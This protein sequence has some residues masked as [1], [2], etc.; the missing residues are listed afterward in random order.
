MFCPAME[1]TGS[2][3]AQVRAAGVVEVWSTEAGK[4]VGS[5]ELPTSSDP[6]YT[7]RDCVA[8][9][10]VVLA[11]QGYW[12]WDFE[13]DKAQEIVLPE[14]RPNASPCLA[15]GADGGTIVVAH[16]H[17]TSN[18]PDECCV[19]EVCIYRLD[20]GELL[21]N[22]VFHKDYL[23]SQIGAIALSHDGRELAL[24]WDFGPENPTRRLVHMHA[25]NGKVLKII[26][27]LPPADQGYVPAPAG[28]PRS[29]LAAR[30][31]R[32]GRQSPERC[33]CGDRRGT[34]AGIARQGRHGGRGGDGRGGRSGARRRWS[35]PG[36]HCRSSRQ[37]GP[38]G[39]PARE[40]H[41]LAE[42]RAVPVTSQASGRF[43]CP[44]G[45]CCQRRQDRAE[46]IH[47]GVRGWAKWW[48]GRADV[49]PHQ[50]AGRF[51]VLGV[52]AAAFHKFQQRE[53]LVEAIAGCRLVAPFH[54][55]VELH[56]RAGSTLTTPPTQPMAPTTRLGRASVSQPQNTPSRGPHRRI[57]SVIR[58]ISPVLS[59]TYW[60]DRSCVSRSMKAGRMSTPVRP[61]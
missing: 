9:R 58:G 48:S 42:T 11:G 21:G 3:F 24:L 10:V 17:I 18:P 33:R 1:G 8:H 4:L 16:P 53:H 59:L 25:G 15:I 61:G 43:N 57:S 28:G 19:I 60:T 35:A 2:W 26:E 29:R 20:T 38:E 45:Q 6:P 55:C 39:S 44:L 46:R 12:V 31:C 54:G 32:L 52:L 27:G 41:R 51:D 40:V 34:P 22:Q 37:S 23:R 49:V 47:F 7:V 56:V 50:L 30:E 5:Q 13:S 14:S 36:D